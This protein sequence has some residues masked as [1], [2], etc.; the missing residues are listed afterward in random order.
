MPHVKG[1]KFKPKLP[2]NL[3]ITVV[4]NAI[5]P[6]EPRE[7]PQPAT[8][9][10]QQRRRK[11]KVAAAAEKKKL[12]TVVLP[13]PKGAAIPGAVAAT[14][15]DAL[16]AAMQSSKGSEGRKVKWP[17]LD[18]TAPPAVP[19]P[20]SRAPS[21]TAALTRLLAID[22]E[23][24]GVGPDGT[25]SALARVSIVNSA[26]TV[27]FDSFVSPEE[28]V[29][30]YRTRWSGVRPADLKGASALAQVKKAVAGMLSGRVLIGH[31]VEN[32]LEALGLRH[33]KDDVRDT[34]KYPPL[35]KTAV[36][37]EQ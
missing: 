24:V 18:V 5:D 20:D 15:W 26:G 9:G 4:E 10:E 7:A 3:E 27:V 22:C 11:A 12:P 23:M 30:D 36:S 14:N 25:R 33:P 31:G 2:E 21:A 17:R 16:R 29:T 35:M 28:K 34:A 8:D 19:Q 32:D 13:P 1:N 37:V 6:A